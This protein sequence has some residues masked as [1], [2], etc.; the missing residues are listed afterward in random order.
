MQP[1]REGE[2]GGTSKAAAEQGTREELQQTGW[3]WGY[4][5]C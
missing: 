2:Q 3:L 5:G 4:G 1:P